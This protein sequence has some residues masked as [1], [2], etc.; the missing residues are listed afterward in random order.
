MDL[1]TEQRANI[2]QASETASHVLFMVACCIS[3]GPKGRSCVVQLWPWNC[4][5]KARELVER[6]IAT[7]ISLFPSGCD[8]WYY[9]APMAKRRVKRVPVKGRG[10]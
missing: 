7:S 2:H 6:G 3:H 1:T 5:D 8:D 9:T 10:V 4:L